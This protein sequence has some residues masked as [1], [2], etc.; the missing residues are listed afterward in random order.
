[1]SKK[2]NKATT[3]DFKNMTLE[4]LFK[5]II[6]AELSAGKDYIPPKD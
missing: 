6:K 5:V 3:P 4:E 2:K 1:M